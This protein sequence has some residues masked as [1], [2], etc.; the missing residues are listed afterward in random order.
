MRTHW[1]PQ[2][3]ASHIFIALDGFTCFKELKKTILPLEKLGLKFKI[4][5]AAITLFGP[6]LL[7]QARLHGPRLFAD[8]KIADIGNTSM[9]ILKAALIKLRP[10]LITCHAGALSEGALAK[11]A[12]VIPEHAKSIAEHDKLV[13]EGEQHI[14][15]ESELAAVCLT[16]DTTPEECF[17]QYR[18]L[19][20]RAMIRFAHKAAEHGNIN[21]FI[22]AVPELK[23]MRRHFPTA[24]LIAVGVRPLWYQA[25]STDDQARIGT[26][27][28]AILAG[29]D[30]IVIGRPVLEAADPVKAAKLIIEEVADAKCSLGP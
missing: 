6:L 29:A 16:S 17:R 4:T 26:P 11:L 7:T 30:D 3:A 25:R 20:E 22:C 27:T 19:P 8:L 18:C 24:R 9:E 21:T 28:E 10:G 14:T 15:F 23:K 13:S 5:P 2:Q 1:T 12:K